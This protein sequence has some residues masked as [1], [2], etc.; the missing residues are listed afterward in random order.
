M[1]FNTVLKVGPNDVNY[2]T[3]PLY[4]SSGGI[5]GASALLFGATLVV[6]RKFSASRFWD[7][8]VHYKATVSKE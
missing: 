6:R 4:H 8:C 3:L 7:E 5:I 2:C 1:G